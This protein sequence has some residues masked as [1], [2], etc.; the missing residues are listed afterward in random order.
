MTAIKTIVATGATSNL[1]FE[2]VKLLL[3][4]QTPYRLIL[5]CRDTQRTKSAYDALSYDARHSLTYLPL[6]LSD[7]PNVQRFAQQ[8]LRE[9][10]SSTTID[11]LFLNAGMIKAATEP[12]VNG[13]RWCESLIVNHFSQHY[14]THLLRGKLTPGTGRVVI[15]SS[16]P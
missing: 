4:E 9:L 7:L 6:E 8:T 14:L 16:G 13:A 15:V 3:K 2:A 5:G 12:G 11:Y 1:G 10:G